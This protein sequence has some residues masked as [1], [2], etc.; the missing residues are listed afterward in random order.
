MTSAPDSASAP[1]HSLVIGISGGIASGKSAAARLLAGPDG[2]VI[3]ADQLAREALASP[4]VLARVREHFGPGVFDAAGEVDRAALAGRV[5]ED[6]AGRSLLE[7]WIH[8]R[9]RV[10]MARRLEESRARQVPRIVLDVPLLFENDDQHQLTRECDVLV[11]VDSNL[12]TRSER[13]RGA[14]G[15]QPD[16]LSRREACQLPLDEK[17][18][19][20]DHVLAN[21]GDLEQLEAAVRALNETLTG[22]AQRP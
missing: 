20:S 1:S 21:N 4:E 3:D 9:V 15:W 19:R 13:A 2:V 12:E 7:G 22:R 6:P 11:F 8:P 16:E 10:I 17:R 14:R 18:E 5:F